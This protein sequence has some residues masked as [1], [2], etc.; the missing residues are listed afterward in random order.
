V[1]KGD[2]YQDAGYRAALV[3]ML[4]DAGIEAIKPETLT[5]E[6]QAKLRQ[7]AEEFFRLWLLG[8]RGRQGGSRCY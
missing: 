8:K 7:Y 2:S 4:R 3:G 1:E 6:N 5:G